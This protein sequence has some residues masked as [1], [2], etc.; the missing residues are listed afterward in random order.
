MIKRFVAWV[1]ALFA[2]AKI[3]D[4]KVDEYIAKQS[5]TKRVVTVESRSYERPV[6]NVTVEPSTQESVAQVEA[7]LKAAGVKVPV[8]KTP[9]KPLNE[10]LK[11]V[12]LPSYAKGKT[13]PPKAKRQFIKQAKVSGSPA[14][15]RRL[16]DTPHSTGGHVVSHGIDP[17][18]AAL[19]GYAAGAILSDDTP[20]AQPAPVEECR[21]SAATSTYS[22]SYSSSDDSYSSSSY[23]SSSSSSYDS[24]SYDSGSSSSSCD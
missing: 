14:P 21:S 11:G 24:S 18:N 8:E 20:A 5:Q 15:A 13:L 10:Q 3:D 16:D 23:G 1:K 9:P 12:E 7:D 17:V 19:Y 22:S 2:P 4:V 6:V